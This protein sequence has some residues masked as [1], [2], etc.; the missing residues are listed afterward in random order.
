M[1]LIETEFEILLA[2]VALFTSILSISS[3]ALGSVSKGSFVISTFHAVLVLFLTAYIIFSECWDSVLHF[4]HFNAPSSSDFQQ[5]VLLFS[6]GYFTVDSVVVL[7]LAPDTSAALHHVSI[8]IGQLA[9]IFSGDFNKEPVNSFFHFSG[10]SGYPLACF[11]FAAEISAPF[12]NIFMSGFAKEGSRLQ[13]FAKAMFAF[14]FIVSRLVVSPFLTYEFVVNS[15]NAPWVVKAVCV[16][17]MGISIYWSRAIIAGVAEALSPSVK[18]ELIAE[19][20]TRTSNGRAKG[21]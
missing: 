5:F 7:W 19:E 14:T 21:E 10:A 8:V 6:L 13:F 16:F 12:L 18:Q 17:V 1:L 11:L 4:C 15:T 20:K 9:A 3:R 2:S